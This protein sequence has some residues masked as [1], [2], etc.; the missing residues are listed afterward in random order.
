MTAPALTFPPEVLAAKDA[1]DAR[2]ARALAGPPVMGLSEPC[3]WDA[4]A[5]CDRRAAESMAARWLHDVL[6]QHG[7]IDGTGSVRVLLD[8]D[9]IE[10][11]AVVRVFVPLA[12]TDR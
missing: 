4:P 11:S 8:E 6:G 2:Q 12:G 10:V 3:D 5:E 7:D 1:R 9:C